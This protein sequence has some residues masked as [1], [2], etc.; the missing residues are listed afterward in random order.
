MYVAGGASSWYHPRFCIKT[1]DRLRVA[2]EREYG[3]RTLARKRDLECC[4]SQL[5]E[6]L[7]CTSLATVLLKHSSGKP[8]EIKSLANDVPQVWKTSLLEE[9]SQCQINNSVLLKLTCGD[10]SHTASGIDTILLAVRTA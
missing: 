1:L 3:T 5:I 9:R 7:V 4:D 8:S 10:M 2:L 6:S